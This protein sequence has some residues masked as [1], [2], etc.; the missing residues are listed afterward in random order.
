MEKETL[1][2]REQVY[3]IDDDDDDDCLFEVVTMFLSVGVG[4]KHCLSHLVNRNSTAD[5]CHV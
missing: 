1:V 5:R 2:A 3:F 4:S